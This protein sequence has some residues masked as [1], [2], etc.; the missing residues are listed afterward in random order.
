MYVIKTKGVKIMKYE[1]VINE[2]NT[3]RKG[4]LISVSYKSEPTLTA[5]AKKSGIKV[6]KYTTTTARIGITY[7][8][9]KAVKEQKELDKENGIVRQVKTQWWTWK[10]KNLIK[11]NINNGKQYLTLTT[12]KKSNPKVIYK[13][14]GVECTKEQLQQQKVVI[15]SYWNT[16]EPVQQYDVNL[17]NLIDIKPK[18][19]KV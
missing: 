16:K 15:D 6:E 7:A 1:Q 5:Q 19:I 4:T 14:N 10:D 11:E 3:R 9:I 8:N 13:V 2:L 18:K 12:A 17:D